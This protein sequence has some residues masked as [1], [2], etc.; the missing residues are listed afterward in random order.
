MGI[1]YNDDFVD[2]QKKHNLYLFNFNINLCFKTHFVFL[3]MQI[4]TTQSHKYQKHNNS[5][6]H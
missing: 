1:D 2:C 6:K 5:D 3:F 4:H